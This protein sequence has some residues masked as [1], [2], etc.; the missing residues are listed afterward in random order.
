MAVLQKY[1]TNFLIEEDQSD[2]NIFKF[3]HKMQKTQE[4]LKKVIPVLEI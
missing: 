4:F 3:K 1:R 2:E